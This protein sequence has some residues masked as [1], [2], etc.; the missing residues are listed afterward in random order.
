MIYRTI[1]NF[2]RHSPILGSRNSAQVANSSKSDRPVLKRRQS[3]PDSNRLEEKSNSSRKLPQK[4][5]IM[6]AYNKIIAIWTVPK[7]NYYALFDPGSNTRAGAS[8]KCFE[9]SRT[10]Y[11][12]TFTI[13]SSANFM[14]NPQTTTLTPDI[15]RNADIRT[16]SERT[17][18]CWAPDHTLKQLSL[19][20]AQINRGKSPDSPGFDQDERP[21]N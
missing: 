8:N 6:R 4:V 9:I 21:H 10:P 18:E 5:H 2:F 7:V 14:D 3:D 19:T 15:P 17:T 13:F 11:I 12:R 1:P 20:T 16:V